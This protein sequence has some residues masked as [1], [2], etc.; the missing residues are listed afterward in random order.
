MKNFALKKISPQFFWFSIVFGLNYKIL[1][2]NYFGSHLYNSIHNDLMY[3]LA[4]VNDNY[5]IQY[6]DVLS[7]EQNLFEQNL[8]KQI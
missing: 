2:K 1:N 7:D 5:E 3:S 4:E 8:E 6:A